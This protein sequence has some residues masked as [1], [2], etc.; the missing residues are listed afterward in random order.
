MLELAPMKNGLA[1]IGRF[2]LWF[3][4]V[5]LFSIIV[6]AV[7]QVSV[8]PAAVPL[9]LT[10]WAGYVLESLPASTAV[11]VFGA[12][13]VATRRLRRRPSGYLILFL[14]AVVVLSSG[15]YLSRGVPT[16]PDPFR[17]AAIDRRPKDASAPWFA[18]TSEETG[19]RG[20]VYAR[21]AGETPRLAWAAVGKYIPEQGVLLA[22]KTAL[23]LPLA[24]A[25]LSSPSIPGMSAL[26]TWYL[27]LG[28]GNLMQALIAVAGT[29]TLLCGLWPLSRLF[30]WPLIGCLASGATLLLLGILHSVLRSPSVRDI[31]EMIGIRVPEAIL[32]AILSGACGMLLLLLDFVLCPALKSASARR[33]R[34]NP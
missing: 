29:A 2:F 28:R 7:G 9:P 26:R 15:V 13:F 27:E 33:N 8:V 14:L 16:P 32:L 3:L 18:R 20:I 23:A 24:T 6:L 31:A 12:G 1:V 22:D 34:G 11:A 25:D 30:R 17:A 10:Y 4:G 21:G 5:E 19:A